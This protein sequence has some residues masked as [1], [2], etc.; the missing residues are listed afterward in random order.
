MTGNITISGSPLIGPLLGIAIGFA[1]VFP[2]TR[3]KILRWPSANSL[4]RFWVI[5]E[6]ELIASCKNKT[7]QQ[8]S[9]H[10]G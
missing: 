8:L 2:V 9:E 7:K 4:A 6:A 3:A 10:L 1:F 5:D